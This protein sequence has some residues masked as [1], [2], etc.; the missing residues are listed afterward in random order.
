MTEAQRLALLRSAVDE[1]ERT[2]QG[3]IQWAADGKT[4]LHWKTAL[5]RLRKLE[6]DLVPPKVPALGPV[7][8]GGS[9]VLRHQLTHNTD[10]VPL[11]P[12]FDDAFYTGRTVIAP[13]DLT[14]ISPYTSAN[15]GAAF[16]AL[17][18]SKIRY[19]FGHTTSSPKIGRRFVKGEAMSTVAYQPNNKS[20]FHVGVNVELLIGAGRRLEYGANGNGPDYTY[21]SPTIGAQLAALL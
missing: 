19:W 1:L 4:G 6:L 9:S 21:G 2:G 14:V 13:E 17:G 20:H 16:Y 3:Y 10:G 18:K 11:Y 5:A 7:W 8:R 15:P 12:A